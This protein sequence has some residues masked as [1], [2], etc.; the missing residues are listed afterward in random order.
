MDSTVAVIAKPRLLCL[1]NPA[2]VSLTMSAL[3]PCGH[4]ISCDALLKLLRRCTAWELL[5]ILSSAA[6]QVVRQ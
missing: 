5:W 2:S 6:V 4:A 3:V 1:A